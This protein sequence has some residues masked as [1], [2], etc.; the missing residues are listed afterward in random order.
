MLENVLSDETATLAVYEPIE[1]EFRTQAYEK[2]RNEKSTTNMCDPCWR[3]KGADVKIPSLAPKTY[4]QAGENI[5]FDYFPLDEVKKPTTAISYVARKL[6]VRAAGL[7]GFKQTSVRLWKSF[8]F[9]CS[10]RRNLNKRYIHQH[11]N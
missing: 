7:S 5:L 1:S 6:P 4:T 3:H 11:E 10:Y 2:W 8:R 9:R